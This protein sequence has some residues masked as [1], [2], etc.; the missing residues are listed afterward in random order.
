MDSPFACMQS[1]ILTNRLYSRGSCLRR[2][3]RSSLDVHGMFS[4]ERG[5]GSGRFGRRIWTSRRQ[6]K[7]FFFP[8]YFFFFLKSFYIELLIEGMMS[9]RFLKLLRCMRN[10]RL[11]LEGPVL[12]GRILRRARRSVWTE[13]RVLGV[14][15]V[16]SCTLFV[17]ARNSY[18]PQ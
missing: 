4:Q 5:S 2:E 8:L 6:G 12:Q 17:L 3:S 15:V 14:G 1:G 7:H 9:I 10:R 18:P 11:G 13:R 16:A